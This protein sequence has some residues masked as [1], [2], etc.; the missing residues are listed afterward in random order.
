MICLG[1]INPVPYTCK[2]LKWGR[3]WANSPAAT[4][5]QF[6]LGMHMFRRLLKD[7]DSKSGPKVKQSVVLPQV[8][9]SSSSRQRTERIRVD[10][11]FKNAFGMF[12]AIRVPSRREK[13]KKI[14]LPNLK[15]KSESKFN[16]QR[17][18]IRASRSGERIP[19]RFPAP[20]LPTVSD[21][22]IDYLLFKVAFGSTS[23]D[24][25]GKLLESPIIR[26]PARFIY[27]LDYVVKRRLVYEFLRSG[28]KWRSMLKIVNLIRPKRT[29]AQ[30][31]KDHLKLVQSF[32]TFSKKASFMPEHER[33]TSYFGVLLSAVTKAARLLPGHN[34]EMSRDRVPHLFNDEWWVT[35]GKSAG[36]S[37]AQKNFQKQFERMGIEF[38]DDESGN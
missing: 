30:V 32:D 7:R 37:L 27:S 35:K 36:G 5:Y 25:N 19:M 3:V 21:R 8:K 24:E 26:T 1:R 9:L 14:P 12:R 6:D 4:S 28:K 16:E 29:E 11:S 17:G 18:K 10:K 34:L 38:I 33:V 13:P 2:T 15:G 23:V 20:H 31:I 22:K